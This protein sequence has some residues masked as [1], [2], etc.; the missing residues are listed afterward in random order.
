MKGKQHDAIIAFNTGTFPVNNV[1][2]PLDKF[3]AEIYRGIKASQHFLDLISILNSL[4]NLI[5]IF[6]NFSDYI[7]FKRR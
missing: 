4:N 1:G 2:V 3:D 5:K 6:S 7:Y